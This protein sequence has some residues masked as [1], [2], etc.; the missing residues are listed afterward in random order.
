MIGRVTVGYGSGLRRV[1]AGCG[2]LRQVTA[3][4]SPLLWVTAARAPHPDDSDS[5]ATFQADQ[6]PFE[7]TGAELPGFL[8]FR[9]TVL[10]IYRNMKRLRD[11]SLSAFDNP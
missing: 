4:Y 5:Q 1:T 11:T 2:G 3:G 9:D 7:R 6:E 8:T 10:Y